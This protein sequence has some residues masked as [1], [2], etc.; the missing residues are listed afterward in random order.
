MVWS[1]RRDTRGPISKILG[2]TREDPIC[3]QVPPLRE[4]LAFSR[5][6]AGTD[7]SAQGCTGQER[8]DSIPIREREEQA[9]S[10]RGERAKQQAISGQRRT[11]GLERPPRRRRWSA[12]TDGH[13]G[14]CGAGQRRQGAGMGLSVR[15]FSL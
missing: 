4:Q 15:C 10:H 3:L 2:E 12:R 6:S 8:E 14:A 11:R 5:L 9:H 1:Q 13:G 7:V